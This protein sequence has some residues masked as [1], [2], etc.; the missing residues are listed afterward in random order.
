M[1]GSGARSYPLSLRRSLPEYDEQAAPESTLAT[2]LL[3][4]SLF[5]AITRIGDRNAAMPQ[6]A[7]Q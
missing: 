7:L 6:S 1:T 2:G 3:T 5:V 4:V